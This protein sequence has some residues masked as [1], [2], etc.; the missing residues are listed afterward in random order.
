[1]SVTRRYERILF[2][3]AIAALGALLLAADALA[4]KDRTTLISKQSAGAGGA[5]GDDFA[6][7]P[8]VSASGRY[9]AFQTG[10]DN[11]GGPAE[12][13]TN[14][15]LYDRER[16]KV[17]LISRQSKSAGGA[18]A[19]DF[20]NDPSI[21]NSGRYVSFE[22]AADNLGGPIDTSVDNIYVYDRKRDK[23]RLVSRRSQRA[24]GAAGDGFS[25]DPSISGNGR[26]VAFETESTNLGGPLNT[27]AGDDNVYVYDLQRNRI[28]LVSRANN[29]AGA[30]DVSRT[31]SEGGGAIS[32]SGRY[33]VFQSF[34]DNLGGPIDPNID[35]IYVYD[36]KRD[37]VKLASRRSKGAG[38]A[39]ADGDSE[40]QVISANGRFVAFDTESTNLGGPLTNLPGDANVYVFDLDR[41]KTQLVSR[42]SRS[43][44][45][46]GADGFSEQA[47]ISANGR[48]VAFETEGTNLGGPL[49]TLA[50]EDNVYV[51]DRDR[52]KVQLVS[53]RSKPAGNQGADDISQTAAISGS[54]RFVVFETEATNL[55]GPL[56]NLAGDDNIYIRDRG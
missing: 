32:R 24:G 8:A 51:Y 25:N 2:L 53:R 15:Y 19:D 42:R 44:G 6:N 45:G 37:K 36:R 41:K 35:N 5:G 52:K 55:G 26:Y 16:K 56:G 13:V 14:I 39:G 7:D 38:G 34:A 12:D 28:E 21:S 27:L 40:G 43:A 1:M 33:V 3:A 22:T 48:F 18:G 54:G 47:S 49:N 50:G 17:E 20:A 4:K 46:A 11:L 23:V 10:A 9:V 29:G 31:S 30:D